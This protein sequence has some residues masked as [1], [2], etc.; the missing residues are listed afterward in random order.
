MSLLSDIR[1]TPRNVWAIVNLLSSHKG[2]LERE[3]VSGWLDPFYTGVDEHGKHKQGNA[4]DQALGAATSLELIETDRSTVRLL[5][6]N[7]PTALPEFSD[8]VHKR[9]IS[10]PQSHPD[11]VVLETY[12]WFLASCAQNRGTTWIKTFSSKKLAESINVALLSD[13]RELSEENRFGY[14]KLPRWRDWVGFMGLGLDTPTDHGTTTAFYPYV[15]ERMEREAKQLLDGFGAETEI[16]ASDFLSALVERMPYLDGGKQFALAAKRIGMRPT[17]RQLSIV[18]STALRE[19]HDEGFLQLK[20]YGDT[21]DAYTLAP[22][23]THRF[24]SFKTVTLKSAE[25]A[26]G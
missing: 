21:R 13:Q 11:S 24:D 20:M 17:P 4:M 22:D 6:A 16:E 26:H 12:A 8:W 3:A 18:I 7:P 19:L 25:G 23:P 9:L 2:E 14:S 1:G 15:T 5:V 10:I